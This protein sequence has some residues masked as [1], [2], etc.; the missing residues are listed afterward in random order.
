[1][2]R[3]ST[4]TTRRDGRRRDDGSRMRWL[5]TAAM[6]APALAQAVMLV[7]LLA[8]G[9]WLFATM[10]GAGCL[11]CVATLV[12]SLG[13]RRRGAGASPFSATPLPHG[14][15]NDTAS[16]DVAGSGAPGDTRT[17]AVAGLV[18]PAMPLATALGVASDAAPWRTVARRWLTADVRRSLAVVVGTGHRSVPFTLD[19]LRSGPHAIV[20]GTTGSGKSV[21]LQTWCVAMAAAFPPWRLQFLL[22]DFKGGSALDRLVGLPHVRGCVSDLDLKH[23]VRALEAIERELKRRERLAAAAGVAD[24][25]QLPAAAMPPRLVVIVDEFHAL[26]GQ[27][28]DYVDRLVRVASLGRS[29]GMHV[30]ACTQHP[31]G[32]ISPAMK[33]NMALRLCLRVQDPMQSRDMLDVP[34]AARI[35]TG[36]PGTA[37]CSD[38][39]GAPVPMRAACAP[40][41]AELERIVRHVG[42]AA[43]FHGHDAEP[44]LFTA[45]LPATVTWTAPVPL[46]VASPGSAVL[47]VADTGVSLEPATVDCLSGNF[48]IVGRLGSGRTTALATLHRQLGSSPCRFF[49]DADRLL[50]PLADDAGAREFRR[51][52]ADPATPVV[53]TLAG[54][55]HLRI[56]DHCTNRLVFPCGE[57]AADLADGVPAPLLASLSP[58]DYGTPGRGVLLTPGT[59]V[60][61]QCVR[62]GPA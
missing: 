22:L 47:G 37:L 60:L 28:P 39:D 48:A 13:N 23:A 44:P 14:T 31:L 12:V 10:V 56:P 34:D 54:S 3:N 59:A 36:A 4:A 57:R 1:M 33:A 9:Q 2:E 29:L 51:L 24:I 16:A 40:S 19:L 49:D 8:Q 46:G 7:A 5:A 45:P 17:P 32:Q 30:V 15:T 27:L 42:L 6:A 26:S 43:K 55:R 25:A 18:L 35:A 11:G 50:D 20:A 53:F 21:L 41:A 38:G 61:V 62:D 58:R 52:L